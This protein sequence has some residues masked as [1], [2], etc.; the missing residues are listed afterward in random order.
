MALTFYP[1]GTAQRVIGHTGRGKDNIARLRKR[2]HRGRERVRAVDKADAHKRSLRAEDLRVYLIQRVAS[3]V[4]I[5]V[6]RR[7]GKAAVGHAVILKRLHHA[8]R[9]RLGHSVY[10][11]KLGLHSRHRPFGHGIYFWF[12]VGNSHLFKLHNYFFEEFAALGEILEPVKRG[13]G[14]REKDDI[15]FLRVGGRRAHGG[16][17][18]I[19][20]AELQPAAVEIL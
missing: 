20:P 5:A 18:I 6:A 14:G 7:S 10:F 4:V 19:D 16:F 8:A 11:F 2:E 13:A 17:K 15:P 3:K 12:Y 1:Y 9:V